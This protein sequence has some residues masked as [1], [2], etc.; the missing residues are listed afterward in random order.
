[1]SIIKPS[2][3]NHIT[4][5]VIGCGLALSGFHSQWLTD[6]TTTGDVVG[7][8][9]PSFGMAI[10][11][12]GSL[13]FVAY[14]WRALDWGEK[15]VFIPLLVIA[16]SMGLSG[17]VVTEGSW[18]DKVAPLFMGMALL[19]TYLMARKL[20]PAVF[21]AFI[22]LAAIVAVSIIFDGIVNPGKYT[23]GIFSN[24]NA[25]VG[26]MVFGAI[27]NRGKWQWVMGTLV[28]VTLFFGGSLEGLFTAAVFGGVVL[29]R[30]DWGKRLLLCVGI[31]AVVVAGWV[32]MGNLDWLWNK[33]NLAIVRGWVA[34]DIE[35]TDETV[36]VATTGR[37]TNIVRRADDIRIMGRGYWITMPEQRSDG[38][39]EIG[40]YEYTHPDEAPVHNVPL[41][42][43]DQ[44]GP[45]AGFAWLFV[46]I[47]CLVRT[48]W[49][50]AWSV[51]L[52]LS[53]FDHYVWTQFAPYWWALAG[54]S[55][56][57]S[58]QSDLIFRT[59]AENT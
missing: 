32:S 9:V 33:V 15:K 43:V 4:A 20:G 52:I 53:V 38:P 47:Y 50:Y 18:S 21:R 58:L 40:H 6:L 12:M 59:G 42:I 36:D 5:L 30:E 37:W 55:T 29:I 34:G 49:K 11:L 3:H 14:N 16:G 19:A 51:I 7:F 8:F 48:R 28:L 10:W 13:M 57:F 39:D 25:V 54:V 22:P 35:F 27:A 26:F 31:T 1:M 17:L 44:V 2:R 56:A 24:Y 46:T 45:A 23:G 41:V